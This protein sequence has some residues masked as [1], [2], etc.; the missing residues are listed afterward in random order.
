MA[1]DSATMS[2]L[3]EINPPDAIS[4]NPKFFEAA[5]EFI[6]VVDPTS[7]VPKKG[8]AFTEHLQAC[9]LNVSS[10]SQ[11]EFRKLNQTSEL[12]NRSAANDKEVP[13]SSKF[14]L[15]AD[16]LILRCTDEETL[17]RLTAADK[18]TA[19]HQAIFK[20]F[21][22]KSYAEAKYLLSQMSMVVKQADPENDFDRTSEVLG[23]DAGA[24]L[25]ASAAGRHAGSMSHLLLDINRTRQADLLLTKEE[26]AQK[27]FNY[28]VFKLACIFERVRLY[29]EDIVQ[30]R[31]NK[32]QVIE[33]NLDTDRNQMLAG[34]RFI[35]IWEKNDFI[36]TYQVL[37]IINN[38]IKRIEQ[39]NLD[40]SLFTEQI[41]PSV[42]RASEHKGSVATDIT[43]DTVMVPRSHAGGPGEE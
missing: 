2:E 27:L 30:P 23:A 9:F 10:A 24:R 7:N 36:M 40:R 17:N 18:T 16:D 35:N 33:V 13:R 39:K 21:L 26:S 43:T 11:P 29:M 31:D 37:Q 3:D 14:T 28:S 6:G 34:E 5:Y 42:E 41:L 20:K 12:I 4:Y 25:D 1:T 15:F 8:R 22:T 32:L 19:I 38:E